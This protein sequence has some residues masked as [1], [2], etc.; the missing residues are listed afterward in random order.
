ML[1]IYSLEQA[2]KWDAIVR[3][4]LNYDI[5]W[6]SSYA[7]TLQV[8]GDGDPIMFFYDDGNTRGINVSMKR[9]IAIVSPFSDLL[10]KEKYYD[11]CTPYGYGGWIIEGE[12]IEVLFRTYD[13]WLKDNSIIS[14]F[15]RFHPVIKNHKNC[16]AFYDIEQ[17]GE[18]V[19]MDLSSKDVIWNNLTSENRN[20]IR[21]AEKNGVHVY[22]GNSPEIYDL[23]Q[24]IYNATMKRNNAADYYFFEKDYY[25]SILNDLVPN[26]RVFWAEK[27][28]KVIAA[29]IMIYANGHMNFHLGGSLE[30]YNCFAPNNL[31]MYN[32]AVWGCENG[33][34]TLLLGGGVGSKDDTLLR[35]KKTFCK[36][37]TSHFYTG[38][39][40]IDR[41]K[42]DYLTGLRKIEKSEFFPKY[43][44]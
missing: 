29:S 27:D 38:K 3:S 22:D 35:Y 30:E 8:N 42:Y 23:F 33:Y 20:R 10:E 39:K 44:A 13:E 34:K 14:E 18:V 2:D 12:N 43:R 25:Q 6:L 31:I 36:E 41:E 9:D 19:C 7:K 37:G 40:I 4:F 17:R 15:V 16:N 5:Y 21:K 24:K 1:N 32:G 28:E 11:L 26:S